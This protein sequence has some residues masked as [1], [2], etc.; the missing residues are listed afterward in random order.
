MESGEGSIGTVDLETGKYEQV[1]F[2]DQKT[3]NLTWI[4]PKYGDV[5]DKVRS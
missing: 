3:D 1:A 4:T 5:P 2:Y